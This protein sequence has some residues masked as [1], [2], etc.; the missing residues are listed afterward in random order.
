MKKNVFLFLLLLGLLAVVGQTSRGWVKTGQQWP[1]GKIIM[2]LQLGASSVRLRDGNTSW[3]NVAVSAMNTWN[4]HIGDVQFE[5]NTT[6]RAVSYGDRINS[7]YW[8]SSVLGRSFSSDTLAITLYDY[9]GSTMTEADVIFNNQLSWDSYRGPLRYDRTGDTIN[10]FY[11]VA[12]HELGHVLGLD[13]PDEFGQSVQAQMNS[14]SGDLDGLA[15]DDIAGAQAL[16][17]PSRW[18]FNRSYGWLYDHKTGWF[19]STDFGWLWFSTPEW[20]W[21]SH[22]WG[23]LWGD[24]KANQLW[25]IQFR[26]L[27]SSAD[28]DGWYNSTTLGWLYIG[29]FNGWVWT[30][31][32]GWVWPSR[33]G[34]WFYSNTFGWM[35]ATGDGGVWGLA[36]GRWL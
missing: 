31:R 23:W 30:S 2:N 26:W 28:N 3:N 20:A 22:L 18:S 1:A 11:R 8:S 6:S 14:V 9:T 17:S 21:S 4:S 33:D 10:D 5:Y 36:Q 16:Y 13:H 24:G 25:S 27:R 19:G 32:F 7:V 29:N 35:A 12:L 15:A 34:Q